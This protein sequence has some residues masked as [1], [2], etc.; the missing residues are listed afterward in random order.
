M[1]MWTPGEI[2]IFRDGTADGTLST[3]DGNLRLRRAKGPVAVSPLRALNQIENLT[4]AEL[5]QW[6]ASYYGS[7]EA[8]SFFLVRNR[9]T[10][11]DIDYDLTPPQCGTMYL[12]IPEE[13]ITPEIRKSIDEGKCFYNT[14]ESINP[15]AY[16]A[17]WEAAR[18]VLSGKFPK[19]PLIN[20]LEEIKAAIEVK[21]E[22]GHAEKECHEAHLA[23]KLFFLGDARDY[24]KLGRSLKSGIEYRAPAGASLQT[25]DINDLEGMENYELACCDVEW[26]EGKSRPVEEGELLPS[27]AS[28]EMNDG[29]PWLEGVLSKF[30]IL[31]GKWGWPGYQVQRREDGQIPPDAK[32][33]FTK[34]YCTRVSNYFAPRGTFKLKKLTSFPLLWIT[35]KELFE[36][37]DAVGSAEPH[38]LCFRCRE[39]TKPG[40]PTCGKDACYQMFRYYAE[41]GYRRRKRGY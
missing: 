26:S 18:T 2:Y 5:W 33:S 23:K 20:E 40:K 12:P 31:H 36:E 3:A 16:V 6:F 14:G 19:P 35:L 29:S 9:Q 24:E 10:I 39:P 32:P 30:P 27:I 34:K 1:P 7:L 8:K 4:P 21:R 37:I 28:I 38:N 11:P 22:L 13:E 15:R 25:M 41:P 17:V